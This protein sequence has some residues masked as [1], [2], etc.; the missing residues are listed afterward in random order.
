MH[1]DDLDVLAS[2]VCRR[3]TENALNIEGPVEIEYGFG[4]EPTVTFWSGL[5]RVHFYFATSTHKDGVTVEVSEIKPG[6][7][8]KRGNVETNLEV[9]RG[10]ITTSDEA[11]SVIENFL[12]QQCRFESLPNYGWKIDTL[13]HDKF[14]P[15][16]PDR[17]NSA[18]IVEITKDPNARKWKSEK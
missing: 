9:M 8:I 17:S 14:I 7:Q 16:P 11:W 13:D 15:H 5:R 4:W 10:I 6:Q 1:I 3:V 12:H 2:E 18:N